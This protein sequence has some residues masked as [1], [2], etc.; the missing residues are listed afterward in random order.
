[1]LGVCHFISETTFLVLQWTLFKIEV[2]AKKM[3]PDLTV[4]QSISDSVS[5]S[6]SLSVSWSVIQ[7]VSQ[8]EINCSPEKI[9]KKIQKKVL[10]TF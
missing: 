8:S 6:F 4:S 9:L 5:Q 1:M 2:N 7:S 10:R 3:L